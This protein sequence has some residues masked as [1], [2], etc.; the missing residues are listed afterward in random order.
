[1]ILKIKHHFDGKHVRAHF[2]ISPRQDRTYSLLGM[3]SM[4]VAEFALVQTA[5]VAGGAANGLQVII[6]EDENMTKKERAGEIR[7]PK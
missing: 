1:M 5:M 4:D 7:M 2:F 6:E 3:L